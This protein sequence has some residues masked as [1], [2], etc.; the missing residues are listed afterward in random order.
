MLQYKNIM[1]KIPQILIAQLIRFYNANN[2][3]INNFIN[4]QVLTVLIGPETVQHETAFPLLPWIISINTLPTNIQITWRQHNTTS[5]ISISIN[6]NQ[7]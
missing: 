3:T 4:L 6:S 2:N 5:Q 1:L 7:H